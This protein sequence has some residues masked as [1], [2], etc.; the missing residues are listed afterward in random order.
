[1]KPSLLNELATLQ[2]RGV[3]WAL[4][5]LVMVGCCGILCAT[6]KY[7]CQNMSAAGKKTAFIHDFNLERFCVCPGGAGGREPAGSRATH[8][9]PTLLGGLGQ[10]SLCV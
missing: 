9:A 8:S 2:E 6:L 1:M 4:G 10:V 5:T 7:R 3:T